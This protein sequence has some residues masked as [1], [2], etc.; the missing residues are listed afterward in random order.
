MKTLHSYLLRETLATLV[1]TVAVFT[2]VLLLGNVLKEIIGLLV[3]GQ[4]PFTTILLAIALLIPFVLVF[5]LPMGMLT[6]TLLIFGRFSADNELTASRASGLSLLSLSTPIFLLS[7]VLSGVCAM[8]N[9]Q[10]APACRVAY[11]RVL[12]Q[13]GIN[14]AG[15]FLP[16]RTY[17]KDA[18]GK[19]VFYAGSVKGTNLSDILIYTFDAA[20]DRIDGYA[21]AAQGRLINDKGVLQVQLFDAWIVD[22]KEG[23]RMPVPSYSAEAQFA[24]TNASAEAEGTV[25]L[26]D[27]TFVQLQ[28]ELHRLERRINSSTSIENLPT[29]KLRE[30]L[31]ECQEQ[32]EEL[33]TPLKVQ[34]HRQVSFSFA[35]IGFTLVGIPLGIRA[36]RR[37]TTFGIA[38]ALGLVLI[39]YSFFIIGQ[40]LATRAEYFPYLIFWVPN[41]FFQIIGGLLLWRANRGI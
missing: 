37:E 38:I 36:H 6:A 35:C 20:N 17:I 30:K 14:R 28:A 23:T 13:T 10:V 31:R 21:R 3:S 29:E 32:A 22:L 40:S 25:A 7:V 16:E 11:K 2:F 34:M 41:F 4:A 39:Y 1:M 12:W 24:Y 27:M 15:T 26:S 9:M 33:T 18:K 8:V 5:A 19:R